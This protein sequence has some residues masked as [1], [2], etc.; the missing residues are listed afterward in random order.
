MSDA[1]MALSSRGKMDII[2]PQLPAPIINCLAPRLFAHN[3]YML[4]SEN[5]VVTDMAIAVHAGSYSLAE[6]WV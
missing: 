3:N 6:K 1:C 5:A 4:S 2:I